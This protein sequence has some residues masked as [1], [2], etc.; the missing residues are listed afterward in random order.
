MHSPQCGGP[1]RSSAGE[2]CDLDH[3]SR[4]NHVRSPLSVPIPWWRI[5]PINKNVSLTNR[6]ATY[7]DTVSIPLLIPSATLILFTSDA[8]AVTGLATSLVFNST[9]GVFVL[10]IR[11]PVG[12]IICKEVVTAL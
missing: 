5:H 10:L 12:L 3:T 11:G 8:F 1:S 2:L 7:V 4:P 9:S 6:R